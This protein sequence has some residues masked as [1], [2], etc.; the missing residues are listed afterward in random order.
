MQ[1]YTYGYVRVSTKDQNEARQMI[2]MCDIMNEIKKEEQGKVPC[3]R[4]F[5]FA[6]LLILVPVAFIAFFFLAG[7]LGLGP[8]P[9]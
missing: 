3:T 7:M 2:A 1:N 4:T 5:I 9:T 6:A 8:V